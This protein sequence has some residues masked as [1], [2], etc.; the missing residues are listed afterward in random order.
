MNGGGCHIP[1]FDGILIDE[2]CMA[3]GMRSSEIFLARKAHIGVY[4]YLRAN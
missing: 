1:E 2:M 3:P 4:S